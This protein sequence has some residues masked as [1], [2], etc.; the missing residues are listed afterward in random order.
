MDCP[1]KRWRLVAIVQGGFSY[2]SEL[3][4]GRAPFWIRDDALVK[5]G[6]RPGDAVAVDGTRE[7]RNGD[8]VL[9]EITVDGD[10]SGRIV[11]RYFEDRGEVTLRA[12][13]DEVADLVTS[14]DQLFVIGVI[15]SRIRYENVDEERT[16]IVEEPMGH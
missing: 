11:R 9:A 6:L 12:E 16:R 4:G 14:A 15:T 8:L 13:N 7:P 10:E 5:L 3:P 2:N 1:R